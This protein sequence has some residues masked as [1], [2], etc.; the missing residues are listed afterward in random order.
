M[1][2]EELKEIVRKFLI[3]KKYLVVVDDV[4]TSDVWKVLK[5]SLPDTKNGSRIV[6]TTRIMEVALQVD[7]VSPPHE[8]KPLSDE[9][10]WDLFTK[11][12]IIAHDNTPSSEKCSFPM[13][14]EKLGR[15]IVEK[16]EG[17]PLA[18]VLLGDYEISAW[19]LIKMWIAE[20]FIVQR[21]YE[22]VEDIAE[23]Y[24]EELAGRCMV[25]ITH[26]RPSKYIKKFR[27]HDLL[28]DLLI[29][30]TK[31]AGFLQIESN[32]IT[33]EPFTQSLTRVRR[34]VLNN[35]LGNIYVDPSYRHIRSFF[36]FGVMKQKIFETLFQNSDA[37]G[38]LRLLDLSYLSYFFLDKGLRPNLPKS[39]GKLVH[40]RYLRLSNVDGSNLPTIVRNLRNP[41][42]LDLRY[43]SGMYVKADLLSNLHHLRHLRLCGLAFNPPSGEGFTSRN[44]QTLYQLE[45]L[46]DPCDFPHNFSS[47]ILGESTIRGDI[48]ST[49]GKLPNLVFLGLHN[50]SLHA[51]EMIFSHGGF[52]KLRDLQLRDMEDLEEMNVED[53]S[54]KRL[55]DLFINECT[56]LKMLPNSLRYVT[57]LEKLYLQDMPKEFN[58]RVEKGEEDWE[59]VAHTFPF[60][61][62]VGDKVED[63]SSSS[64]RGSCRSRRLS[65]RKV[66]CLRASPTEWAFVSHI[67]CVGGGFGGLDAREGKSKRYNY[68]HCVEFLDG[69]W[70]R[71][72]KG[73]DEQGKGLLEL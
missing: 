48:I 40:L 12:V 55:R 29:S 60:S 62:D 4:W 42:I 37:F 8:L 33:S 64:W 56:N 41:Q 53:G 31:E 70:R 73:N 51:K 9:D 5:A 38:M 13:Q 66:E 1:T 6:I 28:R 21:G 57:T 23:E 22:I 50:C 58:G 24:L 19:R 71:V 47:F 39:L 44:L 27:I 59:K 35:Q 18:I 20:G 45:K 68:C 32:T 11:K 54:F 67:V 52:T 2:V 34:V 43:A 25:Q 72:K 61:S 26:R 3:G 63:D 16:C 15:K 46:P 65:R 17:L 49:L 14:L 36:H 10:S 30:K 7:P 69:G